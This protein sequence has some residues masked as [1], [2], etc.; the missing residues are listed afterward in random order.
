MKS[1]SKFRHF[2]CIFQH[3]LFTDLEN[4]KIRI[5]CDDDLK[6]FMEES[7]C[8]KIV[9]DFN[10]STEE[11]LSRKRSC[12]QMNDET[13]ECSKKIRRQMQEIDL[14]S[15]SSS[16]DTDDSDSDFTPGAPT[17]FENSKNSTFIDVAHENHD[18]MQTSTSA[19]ALKKINI[20]SVDIIKPSDEQSEKQTSNTAPE[21]SEDGVQIVPDAECSES[22]I[23]KEA[24]VEK[25]GEQN[26]I[27]EL[28]HEEPSKEIKKKP[29]SNRIVISDSSDDE[30]NNNS[31]QNRRFS[32]EPR[33]NGAY[34]SA[35][36]FCNINGNRYES[37]ASYGHYPRHNSS[38]FRRSNSDR[39]YGRGNSYHNGF[40]EH[41]QAFHRNNADNIEALNQSARLAHDQAARVVRASTESARLARDEAARVVRAST[42]M[43][44]N[45][46]AHFNPLFRVS[47]INQHIFSP[48]N[49]R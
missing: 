49:R 1:E 32:D 35:Y 2:S 16:M 3:F 17:S 6:F 28:G 44:S 9:F 20:I 24:Q 11:E 10:P 4:D 45:F 46:R 18:D 25:A 22:S 5:T 23:V 8:H 39:S 26:E 30:A 38:R 41:I 14:S 31:N 7:A 37:R 13:S 48:F 15:D 29:E 43:V 40:Q 21:T 42:D 27:Q 47:D 12:S 34:S 36:S 19:D 33:R